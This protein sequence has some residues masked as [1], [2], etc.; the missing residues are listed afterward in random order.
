MIN[1]KFIEACKGI[2]MHCECSILI[3]NVLGEYKAFLTPIVRLKTRECRYHEVV[4]AQD[5]TIL[6][7]NI[8]SNFQTMNRQRLDERTQSIH[9]ESFKFG[10]DDYLWITKVDLNVQV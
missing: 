7:Q 3:L 6:V 8:E 1:N 9:K 4:D 10:T 2:V 5:I